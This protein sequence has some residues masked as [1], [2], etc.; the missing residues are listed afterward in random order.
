[1]DTAY[2]IIGLEVHIQLKTKAKIFCNCQ[3]LYGGIPNSR[4]CQ[5]CLGLPGALPTINEEVINNAIMSGLSLNCT[6]SKITKFD[7]KHYMYP[8]LPKGYQIS[9]YDKPICKDGYIEIANNNTPKKIRINR[10]HMEED[11]GKL[12]HMEGNNTYI[13]YN[14]SGVPLLEIVSEPDISS[15]DEALLYLTDLKE[16][17][18]Y[19]EVSD[20]NMEDGSL[21]CDANI[22]MMIKD[23]NKW[24]NTPIV[25]VKNMNSFKNVKKAIDYETT[26]QIEEYQKTKITNDGKNK[27]TRGW[28]DVNEIT[29]FQRN[30]EDESDYRAIPE[31]DLP[32]LEITQSMIESQKKRL[33]E[34]PKA[35]KSRFIKEYDIT[36]YDATALVAQKELGVYFETLVSLTKH[37]KKAANFIL[38]DIVSILKQKNI[39]IKEFDIPINHIAQLIDLLGD[40]KISSWIGKELFNKMIATGKSPKEIMDSENLSQTSEGELINIIESVLK[41]NQKS[42]SDYKNGKDHALKYLMG[43]VM[44]LSKGKANPVRATE[45]ILEKIK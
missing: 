15:S 18:Q 1:M 11:A 7:R 23:G 38:T 19:L 40:E 26:R 32:Y 29:V 42:I 45:I 36:E 12:I 8:D 41:D 14:R 22:S 3:N 21:R 20:C 35:K 31:P 4:V 10:I 13:D 43:Q 9:Q 28:D 34:L 5:V 44:K 27:T 16:I 25:E 30:K 24:I 17:F 39:S 2:P 33:P 37:H 6:I